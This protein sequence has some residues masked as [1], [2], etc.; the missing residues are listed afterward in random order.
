MLQ[1]LLLLTLAPTPAHAGNASPPADAPRVG[2]VGLHQATLDADDQK[3]AV[4]ALAAAVEAEGRFRALVPEQLAGA[5]A[6][7][8]Q[9]VL[10]EGLLS[11]ARQSLANGRT[12]FNQA[13]WDEA[14]T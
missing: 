4:A 8:E 11:G 5:L 7:R 13:S 12:A 10:E 6:G 3:R 14:V 9:V 2:V 1:S